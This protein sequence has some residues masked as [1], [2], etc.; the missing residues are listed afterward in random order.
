MPAVGKIFNSIFL[1]FFQLPVV[2]TTAIP[3]LELTNITLL[4][5]EIVQLV[6]GLSLSES[7]DL[8]LGNLEIVWRR[9]ENKIMNGIENIEA[10]ADIFTFI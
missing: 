1:I 3:P 6:N 5:G 4:E 2:E 10:I 9:L 8:S 7:T